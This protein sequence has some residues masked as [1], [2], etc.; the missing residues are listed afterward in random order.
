MEINQFMLLAV[1]ALLSA[2]L[3]SLLLYIE[4]LI[5]GKRK[6][7]GMGKENV[8]SGERTIS[9]SRVVGFEYYKYILLFVLIEAFLTF[10][11][12]LFQD[13]KDL[14]ADFAIA[15]GVGFLYLLLLM[16]YLLPR[17]VGA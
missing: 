12:P 16:R 5:S 7:V 10:L 3:F 11:L 15:A 14:G 8:E 4:Y 1:F 17:R 13:G 2:A 9:L 6:N